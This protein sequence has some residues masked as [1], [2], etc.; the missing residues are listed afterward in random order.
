MWCEGG[1]ILEVGEA[2]G[3]SLGD[4]GREFGVYGGVCGGDEPDGIVCG[5]LDV[6]I[7]EDGVLRAH[8]SL[9]VVNAN[10]SGT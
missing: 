9:L 6:Y 7:W 2:G 3:Y 5:L 1:W 8:D 10:T 4:E